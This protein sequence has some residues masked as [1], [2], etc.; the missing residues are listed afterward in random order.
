[1]LSLIIDSR[2]AMGSRLEYRSIRK[3]IQSI[4]GSRTFRRTLPIVLST[5]NIHNEKL[6]TIRIHKDERRKSVRRRFIDKIAAIFQLSVN[7]L[8]TIFEASRVGSI[9]QN[10]QTASN[11]IRNEA[12]LSQRFEHLFRAEIPK[13]KHLTPC[14]FGLNRWRKIEK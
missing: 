2:L 8:H 11:D 7:I 10:F 4:D 6:V 5:K 9:S 13:R 1:M 14:S 3:K 12:Y